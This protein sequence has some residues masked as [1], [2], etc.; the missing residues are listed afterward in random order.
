MGQAQTRRKMLAGETLVGTFVKTPSVDVLEVLILA[1]LDFVCFDGEHAPFDRTGLNACMAVARA[2]D[3]PTL[4]RVPAGLPHEIGMAL[5]A[6]A[7]GVVVPHVTD[8]AT[9][10]AIAKAARFGPGGRGYAGSTRWAGFAT[11]TMPNILSRSRDE[12]IVIAQIED[13]EAVEVCED[14]AAVEGIDGL[15]I[16]PADLTVAYGETDVNNDAL[17]AAMARGGAAAKAAGKAYM[18]F[19]PNAEAGRAL[20]KYGFTMWF[21]ASEHTW[22][23]QGAR[24]TMAGL[25]GDRS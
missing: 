1:G 16:G 2:A 6:G 14:I 3:L 25:K 22:M 10:R 24:A 20:E 18:T 5:D 19:V 15:F 4:V 13:A 11:D 7:T 17:H 21:V 9:A 23:L 8:V 12:T